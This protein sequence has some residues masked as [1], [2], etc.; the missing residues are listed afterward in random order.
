[1]IECF[2]L[3]KRK[4]GR[5]ILSNMSFRAPDGQVTGFLGP[6][7][8]GKS[9]TLRI[10][11]NVDQPDEGR[12]LVNGTPHASARVPARSMGI[13]LDLDAFHPKRTGLQ[14]LLILADY[15]GASK[16]DAQTVLH[17]TG[18][19]DA[20]TTLVGKYSLG[21]KQRL[22]IASALI[23][24]PSN[25]VLDEPLNGLD[26]EGVVWLR[27]TILRWGAEGRCVL[28]SSHQISEV[29]GVADRVVMI[30]SGRIILDSEVNSL[31]ERGKKRIVQLEGEIVPS[32][33]ALLEDMNVSRVSAGSGRVN[34]LVRPHVL[35][36]AAASAGVRLPPF[37]IVD[38]QAEDFYFAAMRGQLDH[39]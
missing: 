26:A 16:K 29:F 33:A 38:M 21:M 37:S 9:S 30:S 8:A 14:H 25:I 34:C 3:T 7:G 20:G 5:E 12:V 4:S 35:M 24:D 6:N 10:V 27:E 19:S 15:A 17:E 2:E 22:S 39:E 11:A 36:D 13:S 1:M 23:G 28:V 18:L 31:V 32:V